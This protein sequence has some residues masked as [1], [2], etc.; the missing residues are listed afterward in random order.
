M[1]FV[2]S[3]ID[4]WDPVGLLFHA[5]SDEYRLEIEE[6]QNLLC[7][8]EDVDDLAEAILKVFVESFSKEIFVKS[9][10]ECAKIAQ[11][12]LCGHSTDLLLKVKPEIDK[13]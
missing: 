12:L 2:K 13:K 11:L 10:E 4:A 1:D 9:K 3:V 7:I 6:I 8:V 5:P